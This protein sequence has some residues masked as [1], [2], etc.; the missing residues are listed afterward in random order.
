MSLSDEVGPCIDRH[1][2]LFNFLLWQM[3]LLWGPRLWLL[4]CILTQ[5]AAYNSSDGVNLVKNISPEVFVTLY[6]VLI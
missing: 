5:S 1:F 6:A 2:F 4:M 3:L